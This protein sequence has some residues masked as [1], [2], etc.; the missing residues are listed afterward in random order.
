MRQGTVELNLPE[1]RDFDLEEMHS[2]DN[3]C[4]HQ[5]EMHSGDKRDAQR[6]HNLLS[7]S[8]EDES[9]AS[10][11]CFWRILIPSFSHRR[12]LGCVQSEV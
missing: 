2:G 7:S 11:I 12:G 4:S 3:I 10:V 9:H 6:G 5:E 8:N 1:T